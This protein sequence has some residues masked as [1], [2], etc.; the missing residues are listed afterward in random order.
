MNFK[1]KFQLQITSSTHSSI[2]Y[3]T[4]YFLYI[5][6]QNKILDLMILQTALPK[7]IKKFTLLKSPHIFKTARTQLER[8]SFKKTITVIN[9]NTTEQIQIFNK[10]SQ[11]LIKNLP[12]TTKV[13]IK[14]S[15]LT[16]I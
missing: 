5:L 16:F 4:S 1:T 13:Q 11:S 6:T 10:I 8:R 12:V 7:K 3:L 15:R 9:F 2:D 14:Y